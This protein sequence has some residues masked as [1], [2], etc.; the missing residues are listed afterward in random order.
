MRHIYLIGLGLLTAT[1]IATPLLAE[2]PPEVVAERKALN[3]AQAKL[4][5][6]Q[7]ATYLASKKAVAEQAAADQSAY[8]RALADR[9]AQIAATNA[10]AAEEQARWQAAVAACNAGDKTKCAQPTPQ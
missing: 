5:A 3:D 9:D 4:A 8:K 10:R 6:D 2:D 1:T 7:V